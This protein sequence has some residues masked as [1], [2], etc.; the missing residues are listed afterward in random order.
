MIDLGG[1]LVMIAAAK[2]GIDAAVNCRGSNDPLLRDQDPSRCLRHTL[3]GK[4]GLEEA[5]R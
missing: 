2:G 1:K 4:L 3:P 5:M